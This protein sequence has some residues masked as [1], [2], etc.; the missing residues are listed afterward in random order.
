MFF[1]TFG[2][3]RISGPTHKHISTAKRLKYGLTHHAR[4]I[5][6]SIHTDAVPWPAEGVARAGLVAQA[7][8]QAFGWEAR[9][10]PTGHAPRQ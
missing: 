1:I 2:E 4:A 5:C 3:S 6:C 7:R 9:T 10:R 8:A